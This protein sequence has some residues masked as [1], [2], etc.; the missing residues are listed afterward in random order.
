[1]PVDVTAMNGQ[2]PRT[3]FKFRLVCLLFLVPATLL[4]ASSAPPS[5][6]AGKTASEWTHVS[7]ILNRIHP[8]TF[9]G[10]E[11]PITE[12]G[13]VSDGKTDCSEA[14]RKAI[15]ACHKGGGGRVV[16]PEGE[17]LTSPIHLQSNVEL[18]LDGQAI[19]KFTT[20]PKAY[21]PVVF[22][23]FEGMECYNYSPLIYAFEQ[24]NIAVTGE[25]TLDGQA[26][27]ENWWQWKGGR[28]AREKSQSKARPRSPRQDGGRECA[29]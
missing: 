29:G 11:F 12:F 27:D 20:E 8:P 26:S 5:D 4:A 10:R 3:V 19:L 7:E 22:T 18:H 25:G 24:E 28:G 16:V 9:P 17:F 14:I 21:L 6:T 23:R 2:S 1:M 15:A 13:A